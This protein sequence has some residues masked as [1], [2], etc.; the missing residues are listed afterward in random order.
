MDSAIADWTTPITIIP[1]TGA[2]I[3]LIFEKS[4][5]NIRSSAAD[6]AVW[7]IVNCHPR[8]EPKQAITARAMT[9]DPIVG[10]NIL[11]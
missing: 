5:G 1:A 4:E 9:I 7:A 3:R 6:L 8:S 10:L 11:A 2:P